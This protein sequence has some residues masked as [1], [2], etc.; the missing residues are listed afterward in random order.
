MF[1]SHLTLNLIPRIASF[2]VLTNVCEALSH[3]DRDYGIGF[4]FR[5]FYFI[6]I[7]FINLIITNFF[8]ENV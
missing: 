3:K 5:K 7:N 6:K 1:D 2:S 4:N 8:D